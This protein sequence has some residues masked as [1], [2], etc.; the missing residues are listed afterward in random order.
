M[1]L[2]DRTNRRSGEKG[3]CSRPK[4]SC[5][6]KF[7]NKRGKDIQFWR[8]MREY[9]QLIEKKVNEE[10]EIATKARAKGFDPVDFVEIP[11]A[12]N[13]AERVEG[14]IASVA[15]QVKDVGIVRRIYELEEQ[16]GI[17]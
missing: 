11:L 6:C 8:K 5:C 1:W 13:M 15:P 10:Y 7:T 9:Q 3:N 17:E 16:Y 12:R 4:Q 14:L 2:L